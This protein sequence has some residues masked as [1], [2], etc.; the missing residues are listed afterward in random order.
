MYRVH[1]IMSAEELIKE[2]GADTVELWE[3]FK[4]GKNGDI[5]EVVEC[6]VEDFIGKKIKVSADANYK[7]LVSA[8]TPDWSEDASNLV[9][10]YGCLGTAKYKKVETYKEITFDDAIKRVKDFRAVYIKQGNNYGHFNK[11]TAFE[12]LG[13][14]DLADLF[15]AKFYIKEAE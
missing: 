15:N 10:L 1:K 14:S 3:I 12:D 7:A 5:Y 8:D 4:D 9:T 6:I 13:I 11:Y 2:L